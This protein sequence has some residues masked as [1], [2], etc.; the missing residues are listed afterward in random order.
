MKLTRA[1][2]SVIITTTAVLSLSACGESDEEIA[3]ASSSAASLSSAAA[4]SSAAD[5]SRSAVTKSNQAKAS[6]AAASRSAEAAVAAA[7]ASAAAEAARKVPTVFSGSGDDVVSITKPPGVD[8]AVATIT[9]SGRSNFVVKALDGDQDLLVNTIGA[10]SG[11]RLMDTHVGGTTQ[12]QVTS[13]GDWTITLSDPLIAPVLN[14]GPNS[15][16]GD[17]VLLY[18][19]SRSKATI[20][21]QSDSNFVVQEYS[22]SGQDLLVNEIGAYEGTVPLAGPAFVEVQ[23]EGTWSITVG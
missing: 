12:L 13:S 8:V 21:G 16:T 4:A 3:A 22:A 5:A 15:G 9:G 6:S 14:A 2:V 23:S 18:Q 20:S 17:A 11:S 19:G 7:S 1:T 10:Y